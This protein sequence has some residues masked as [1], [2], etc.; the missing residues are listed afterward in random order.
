MKTS[1]MEETNSYREEAIHGKNSGYQSA[2][3]DKR[4]RVI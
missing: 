4:E 3:E 2:K 1:K